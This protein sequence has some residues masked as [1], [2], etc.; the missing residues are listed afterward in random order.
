MI[1]SQRLLLLC[2]LGTTT[3]FLASCETSTPQPEPGRAIVIAP[4]PPGYKGPPTQ[5]ELIR[6]A[7]LSKKRA[8]EIAKAASTKRGID[9]NNYEPPSAHFSPWSNRS[10]DD[11]YWSVHFQRKPVN[12]TLQEV[13]FP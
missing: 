9:L 2:S 10:N 3:C 6:Y 7:K 12:G 11:P 4:P 13:I 1:A 5:T 8:I